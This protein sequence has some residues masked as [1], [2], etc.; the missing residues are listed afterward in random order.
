MKKPFNI[1]W[2]DLKDFK[3]PTKELFDK[4][5]KQK[6]EEIEVCN[7]YYSDLSLDHSLLIFKECIA[8][9]APG[10]H[11]LSGRPYLNSIIYRG[12]GEKSKISL[13]GFIAK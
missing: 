12:K 6:P 13:L 11:H 5:S 9:N 4:V 1:P 2:R 3:I 10:L 7:Q 8:C